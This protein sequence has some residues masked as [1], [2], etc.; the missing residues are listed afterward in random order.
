MDATARVRIRVH[1]RVQGVGFRYATREEARRYGL[2][3]WVRN[4]IDGSVSAVVEGPPDLVDAFV[5]WCHDGPVRAYVER[6]DRRAD[7]STDPL[8]DPFGVKR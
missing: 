6:V 4:E 7:T 2:R 8:P 3:G 1:G 5:A